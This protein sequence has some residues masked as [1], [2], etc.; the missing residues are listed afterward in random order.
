MADKEKDKEKIERGTNKVDEWST[1]NPDYEDKLKAFLPGIN[2]SF[3][4]SGI[5]V[6]FGSME[7]DTKS[8]MLQMNNVL[9][10]FPSKSEG[11]EIVQNFI[12]YRKVY[13]YS[14]TLIYPS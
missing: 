11:E 9:L 6:G 7:V 10:S 13:L 1:Q 5:R 12:I 2:Y 3:T 4:L 8:N 14:S